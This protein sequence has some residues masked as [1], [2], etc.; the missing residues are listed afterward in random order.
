MAYVTVS[1]QTFS[2][3]SSMITQIFA[4]LVSAGW[5]L[6]DNQDGSGYRVYKTSNEA[7]DRLT[8]YM[9][10][11]TNQTG[12]IW[13]QPFLYW[14]ASTHAGTGGPAAGYYLAIACNESTNNVLWMMASKDLSVIAVNYGASY[15]TGIFG[16]VPNRFWPEIATLSSSYALSGTPTVCNVSNVQGTFVAGRNY[17]MVGYSSDGT[18]GVGRYPVTV[19]AV[20]AG[21]LTLTCGSNVTFPANSLVGTKPSNFITF[22]CNG[23][24]NFGNCT[25]Q[26]GDA[27]T[28]NCVDGNRIWTLMNIYNDAYATPSYGFWDPASGRWGSTPIL[29]METSSWVGNA[30][31]PGYKGYSDSH[32]LLTPQLAA[33]NVNNG[34]VFGYNQVDSGTVNGTVTGTSVQDTTKNWA[35]NAYAGYALII[36]NGPGVGQTVRISSNTSNTL[37]LSQSV[38]P[39][40]VTA[41]STYSIVQ[42]AYRGFYLTWTTA[43]VLLMQEALS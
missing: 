10:I 31:T 26:L 6:H 36:T 39:L 42:S 43:F 8:E 4:T 28:G 41:N 20:G 27:G 19:T 33:G 3:K 12:A 23:G 22:P 34:D 21:T 37:I 25:T 2:N 15:Y 5:T 32:L 40:P 29:W 35:T 38:M 11:I 1:G 13:F 24:T 17:Q 30:N 14:N 16:H 7:G 9:K 18:G